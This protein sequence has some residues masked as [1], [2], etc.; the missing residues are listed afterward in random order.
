MPFDKLQA[1]LHMPL[2]DYYKGL[3]SR[4]LQKWLSFWEDL[5]SA[6]L[7]SGV[8]S[9]PGVVGPTLGRVSMVLNFLYLKLMKV[10]VLDESQCKASVT[11]FVSPVGI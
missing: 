9:L 8:P 5:S 6:H 10:S 2:T 3:I 11:K 4:V 1:I 7:M